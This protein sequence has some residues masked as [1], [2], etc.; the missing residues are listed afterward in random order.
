[1][2]RKHSEKLTPELRF[3]GF[4][5]E[6]KE[7]Q[8]GE[9]CSTFKSGIG[10]TSEQITEEGTYPVFGGNGLRGYTDEYNHEGFYVLIGRQGALCGCINRTFGKAYISE[11]AIAVQANAEACTEWL[12]QKLDYFQLNRLS[13]SSAQPGLAV[14]KL[15]KVKLVVP[16]ADEQQKIASFLSA[17]D[18]RI[19]QLRRKKELL[20]A[21]KKGVMQK[22]FSQELR[23]QDDQGHPFPDWEEKR[24]GEI[25]DQRTEN[26]YTD[27]D[28]LS[29]TLKKG[30]IRQVDVDKIDNS[31]S[32]K[33][34]YKRVLPDDI[35]YNS[36]R[37]WQG[38]SGVS[39][40]EGIVSPAYT[41]IIPKSETHS[42]YF[43]YFFKMRE[44]VFIFQRHSQG[45]TSDTWNLK[46]PMLA[47]IKFK[48][49][50]KL[51]QQKIADF[52]TSLDQKIEATQTQ[53]TQ[54]ETF[55]KGLLQQMFV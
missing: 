21:Y 55:K 48:I 1:M 39:Q 3:P 30:V 40:Y 25:F 53:L 20:E 7:K 15:L 10:I 22:L 6:W 4:S 29:V 50:C 54:T 34:K 35:A 47:P 9:I 27:L 46:Y 19:G 33:S 51:E 31:N 52:L 32:D 42:K 8:L 28:L 43:G 24:L 18:K 13:E 38:A 44:V 37:M 17:V 16:S 23:F 45:L 11:H 41:V 26:S 36:M 49:P 2:S 12:A 5:G 14:N